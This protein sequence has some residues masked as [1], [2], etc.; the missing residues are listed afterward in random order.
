MT[1]TAAG[2]RATTTTRPRCARSTTWS[3]A[4]TSPASGSGASAWTPESATC[5]TSIED[6]FLKLQA[7]LCRRG[8]LRH[9]RSRQPRAVRPGRRRSPTSPPATAFPDALAA[10][11]AAAIGRRPGAAHPAHIAAGRDRQ[12][13]SR[14]SGRRGSS[15]SAEPRV[16]SDAV[17]GRAARLRHERRRRA[18]WPAPTDTRPPRASARATFAPGVPVAYVATGASFPDALAGGVAAGRQKGPV[19][20]GGPPTSVPGATAAELARLKPGRIVVLGGTT[21][22]Q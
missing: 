3:S 22:S 14:G 18:A 10:G 13:S 6:R 20:L 4:T 16:V 8:S 19:L 21:V 11:P 1:R 5:G 12:P 17:V 7:R 9:R 2:G 15:S